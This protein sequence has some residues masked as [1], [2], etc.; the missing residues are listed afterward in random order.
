VPHLRHLLKWVL[1]AQ[2]NK[3]S[4]RAPTLQ[5]SHSEGRTEKKRR[6]KEARKNDMGR[7]SLMSMAHILFSKVVFI[8]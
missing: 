3:W 8:P 6:E 1:E 7:P 4:Q 5:I 2:A